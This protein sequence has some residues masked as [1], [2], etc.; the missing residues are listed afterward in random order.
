MAIAK[1]N[2]G[3][4][5]T[6]RAQEWTNYDNSAFYETIDITEFKGFAASAGI[7]NGCDIKLSTSHWEKARSVLE[8]GAGYGRVINYLL[9]HK[10][11]GHITAIE[12]CNKMFNH[13]QKQYARNENVTLLH[14]DLHNLNQINFDRT[15]DVIFWL[16]SG[17]TEFSFKEQP[18]IIFELTKL[19]SNNGILI[20]DTMPEFIIPLNAAEKTPSSSYTCQ[21]HNTT[22]CGYWIS[23]DKIEETAFLAGF[24][25]VTHLNY[26]TDTNRKR[27]L[28]FLSKSLVRYPNTSFNERTHV[29]KI[30][31]QHPIYCS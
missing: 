31:M 3:T 6:S 1:N 2:Y 14:C 22:I 12:R 7:T 28:H 26:T 11:L 19:L 18:F 30:F 13:L 27:L 16:W 9:Q 5:R 10:F 15:F 17:I 25:N 8:V 23:K 29:R 20:I 21:M 24:A 4:L